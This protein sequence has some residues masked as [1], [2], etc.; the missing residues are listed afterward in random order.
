MAN[1]IVNTEQ[2]KGEQV[3]KFNSFAHV[4]TRHHKPYLARIDEKGEMD[5]QKKVFDGYGKHSTAYYV[6]SDLKPGDLIQSAGGSGTNTYPTKARVIA[7]TDDTLEVE[8]MTDAEFDN[9]VALRKKAAKASAPEATAGLII[10]VTSRATD[11]HAGIEG[12][13]E[14]WGCGANPLEAIGDLVRAHPEVF[15]ASI[16]G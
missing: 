13:P 4:N 2:I 6:V 11:F 16:K 3:I 12:K 10:I 15:N 7:L 5:W 9:I 14:I 1:T 8:I